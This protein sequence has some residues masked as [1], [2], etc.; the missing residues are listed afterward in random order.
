[1]KTLIHPL[2]AATLAVATSFSAHAALEARPGGMVYDTENNLTWLADLNQAQTSG[3]SADGLMNW[4]QAKAWADNL[5][6]GGFSDWRLPTLNPADTSCSDSFSPGGGFGL[7]H[8]GYGCTGGELSRLFVSQLGGQPGQSLLDPTGKT[9][10]Q[11]ANMALFT[12][13]Q[14]YAYWSGTE[15][16][17]DPGNAGY[18]HT[19]VGYQGNGNDKDVPLY[20]VAVRPGDVTAAVVPEP[21]LY[22]MVLAGLGGLA[23]ARRRRAR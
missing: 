20:A 3:Y 7:Q 16:A 5:V 2:L 12:N 11:V 14:S 22:A 23:V 17:P 9:P 13:A 10:Q 18:F 21:E 6:F 4:N 15:Y 8:Y 1:V 19:Y